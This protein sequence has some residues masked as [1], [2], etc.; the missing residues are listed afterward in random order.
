MQSN[1]VRLCV[2]AVTAV[3]LMGSQRASGEPPATSA[4]SF[5]KLQL[6][7]RYYCDGITVADIDSDG[8]VDVIAGPFW[9]SGPDFQTAHE[10]YEAVPLLPEP[11]PSNSMFSFVHDFSGDGRPDILVL[12]RVHMHEA[13]WYENPGSDDAGLWTDHF[14][15]ERV[16]GESP[17]LV[18]LDG[19][20][21]PQVICHWDGRWGSIEP[22]PQQPTQPWTFRP[23]GANEDWPQFYHGQGTGDVNADGRTDFVINDGWYEQPEDTGSEDWKFH[24]GRFSLDRGGAQM[25]VDDVDGDGDQDVVSALNAHEWGLA[26]FEQVKPDDGT[27]EKDDQLRTIGDRAFRQ[28]LI[29]GDRSNEAT[30]G[31]AFS[32]PHALAYADIDGDG[33]RDIVTGKRLWAHGPTGDVEPNAEPVLYWFRWS[34]DENGGVRFVPQKI[35][36]RS[37]VGTQLTVADINADGRNDV[38]TVSKLG[39]FVFLQTHPHN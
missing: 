15:F 37:G 34:R 19:N 35:D 7:D 18:D 17:A 11:S 10:F 3:T 21:I 24:R 13:K 31:V 38:L 22:N 30:F 12:G 6:T 20:G 1:A 8:N 29:M 36:D 4:V 33:H 25:F 27:D 14:A 16:R 39:T 28:H 5:T 9:Y 23:I 2:A 26:W 32:Q